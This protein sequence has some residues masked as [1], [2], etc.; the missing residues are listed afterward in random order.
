MKKVLLILACG[1][2]TQLSYAQATPKWADKAKKAVFPSLHTI[3]ITKS[4]IQEMD[5]ISMKMERHY[6][7]IPCL[8]EPNAQ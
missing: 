5:S 1:I 4:R 2:A 7:I 6:P 8:K 3:K